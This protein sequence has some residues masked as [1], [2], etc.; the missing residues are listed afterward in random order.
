MFASDSV[1]S[2]W[3]CLGY[4]LKRYWGWVG[5]NFA[6][7]LVEINLSWES[8][9]LAVKGPGGQG[10]R[11]KGRRAKVKREDDLASRLKEH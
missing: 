11:K 9:V 1:S 8:T 4:Y 10:F 2:A 5:S 7:P 6:F 3:V